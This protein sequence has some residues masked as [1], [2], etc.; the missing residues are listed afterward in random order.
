MVRLP[1]RRLR[2]GVRVRDAALADFHHQLVLGKDRGRAFPF[3]L[4]RGVTGIQYTPC[5]IEQVDPRLPM[6]GV[7]QLGLQ[8][9][10][11]LDLAAARHLPRAGAPTA[12]ARPQ[13]ARCRPAARAANGQAR[14]PARRCA[15]RF[16]LLRSRRPARAGVR[17]QGRRW[18]WRLIGS[19]HVFPAT[20]D[21]SQRV[22]PAKA[23][24]PLCAL[25]LD[26]EPPCRS[27]GRRFARDDGRPCD[28]AHARRSCRSK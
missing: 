7:E 21:L 8:V 28:D 19:C 18:G 26:P 3:G 27:T 9:E 24:D 4:L 12:A 20:V 5:G 1:H 15:A 16:D 2:P 6:F 11:L 10:E 14:Q 13:R 22:I 25:R 17:S 23:R